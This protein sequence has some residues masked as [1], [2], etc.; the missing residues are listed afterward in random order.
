MLLF[1]LGRGVR[2]EKQL[3]VV[4]QDEIVD[5]FLYPVEAVLVQ[6]RFIRDLLELIGQLLLEVGWLLQVFRGTLFEQAPLE[7]ECRLEVHSLGKQGRLK[8]K[9]LFTRISD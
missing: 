5:L 9:H 2:A 1:E 4:D 6:Q 7:R 3:V 8:L